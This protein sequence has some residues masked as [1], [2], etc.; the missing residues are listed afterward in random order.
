MINNQ[1][2]V[3]GLK[4]QSDL[5]ITQLQSRILIKTSHAY[6]DKSSFC[7]HPPKLGPDQESRERSGSFLHHFLWLLT[8][9]ALEGMMR[10][11]IGNGRDL[12]AWYHCGDTKWI[13][14]GPKDESVF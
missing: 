6:P 2:L 13:Q 11:V 8:P 9:L 1:S 3:W 4:P 10:E 5:I 12:S 7:P 14:Q